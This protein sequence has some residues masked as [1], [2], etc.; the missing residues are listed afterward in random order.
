MYRMF[1]LATD[2]IRKRFSMSGPQDISA[3]MTARSVRISPGEVQARQQSGSAVTF[4]DARN[5]KAWESSPVK[6]RGAIRIR[7]ADWHIDSSW[8]K[9]RLTVVY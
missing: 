7:P 9:D 6:V 3:Q 5:D 4:L 2:S 8:A 1:A